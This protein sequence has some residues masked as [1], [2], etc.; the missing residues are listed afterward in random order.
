MTGKIPP[1][2]E[3]IYRVV[4][5]AQESAI[6]A[7]RSGVS[8]HEVDQVARGVIEKAGFG[9]NFGHGL[10]HGIG[11]EIHE[12]PRLTSGAECRWLRAWW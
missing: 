7:I 6:A 2:L 8:C 1:K 12:A 3:R 4:L 10:G 9:K 5:T 11:L